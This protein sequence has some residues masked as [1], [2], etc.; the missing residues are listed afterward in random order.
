MRIV[1]FFVLLVLWLPAN[2]HNVAAFKSHIGPITQAMQ[3]NMKKYTWR[4]GCPVSFNELAAVHV[5]YWGFDN[6]PHQGL[7][8]VHKE[9]AKEVVH[10]FHK[11]YVH[12][13]PIHSMKTMDEFKGQD[14]ASMA[15]N[16]TS[17]FN[18]R[19]LTGIPGLFSQHSYGRAIDI[20]P[21]LNPYVDG[22]EIL[23]KSGKKFVTRQQDL[24]GKITKKSIIYQIFMEYDWD[25]GGH[26][27]DVQDYHH[28]EKRA[29]HAKR[30]IHG[31]H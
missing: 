4:Q 23:P 29:N 17:A 20:N 1:M 22:K 7:L 16:N 18:C 8:I 31:Y 19:T 5:T 28:F 21:I 25:W 24:P 30:D 13:F 26:W 2:S 6:K 12:R 27:L 3:Q 15:A 14:E 9:L 10:I 11:L